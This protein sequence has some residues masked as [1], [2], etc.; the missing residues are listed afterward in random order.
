MAKEKYE[1][2]VE[3]LKREDYDS[4][5]NSLDQIEDLEE[6]R[7]VCYGAL[8]FWGLET[9]MEIGHE[10]CFCENEEEYKK[11]CMGIDEEVDLPPYLIFFKNGKGDDAKI[12]GVEKTFEFLP[13]NP[14]LSYYEELKILTGDSED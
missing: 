13:K 11:A 10:L 6:R 1:L 12:K 14:I 9:V 4:A 8:C 7:N 3:M 2:I 5:R